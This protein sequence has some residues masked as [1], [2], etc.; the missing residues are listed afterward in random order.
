MQLVGSVLL[1]CCEIGEYMVVLSMGGLKLIVL[2]LGF[3][4]CVSNLRVWVWVE[5][6]GVWDWLINM[7]VNHE[8]VEFSS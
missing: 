3:R 8:V 6:G 2:N 4:T 1:I 7:L 5:V